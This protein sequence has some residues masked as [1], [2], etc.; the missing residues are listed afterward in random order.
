MHLLCS[1]FLLMSLLIPHGNIC[2]Q[3]HNTIKIHQINVHLRT[4]CNDVRRQE[5]IRNISFGINVYDHE[6]VKYC[7]SDYQN[8]V[9]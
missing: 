2:D 8:Y 4:T 3:K 1:L 6:K 9:V 7:N 5:Y